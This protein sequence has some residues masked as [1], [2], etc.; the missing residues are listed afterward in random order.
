M[1]NQR[2]VE[3]AIDQRG[4]TSRPQLII[5]GEPRDPVVGSDAGCFEVLEPE[6]L[7]GDPRKFPVRLDDFDFAGT[8]FQV[9]LDSGVVG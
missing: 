5:V 2:P 9:I 4:D 8:V 1:R 6:I 3:S 7:V